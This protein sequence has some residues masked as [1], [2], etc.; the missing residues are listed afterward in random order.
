MNVRAVAVLCIPTTSFKQ[1][2][3]V[4]GWQ[5]CGSVHPFV[6]LS[7]LLLK[8]PAALLLCAMDGSWTIWNATLCSCDTGSPRHSS[9][10]SPPA[11]VPVVQAMS[12]NTLLPPRTMLPLSTLR[13]TITGLT[14]PVVTH[15][16]TTAW[17]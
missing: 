10:H 8:F 6:K 7:C 4:I 17:L 1:A 9:P 12:S 13:I 2:R 3:Y 15:C 14:R 5:D 16:N 11:P